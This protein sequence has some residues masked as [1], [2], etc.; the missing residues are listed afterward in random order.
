MATAWWVE[1]KPDRN[2]IEQR[3]NTQRRLQGDDGREPHGAVDRGGSGARPDGIE[4]VQHGQHEQQI[5]DHAMLELH[6]ER[7]VEQIAPPRR[8]KNSRDGDGIK[9]PSMAGQVL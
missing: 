6:R 3:E 9:L 2:L 7:I 8:S 4:R 1:R 5:S